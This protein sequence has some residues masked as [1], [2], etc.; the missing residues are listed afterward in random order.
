MALQISRSNDY[1]SM[2]FGI[3]VVVSAML[4]EKRKLYGHPSSECGCLELDASLFTIA[5]DLHIEG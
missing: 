5:E 2:G 3:G 4:T 1:P